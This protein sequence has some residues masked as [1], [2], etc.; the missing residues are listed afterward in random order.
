VTAPVSSA[1]L[2]CL[3]RALRTALGPADYGSPAAWGAELCAAAAALV[4]GGALGSVLVMDVGAVDHVLHT[5]L[6]GDAVR[7]YREEYVRHDPIQRRMLDRRLPVAYELDVAAPD[8]LR[9]DAFYNEFAVRYRLRCNFGVS[10]FQPG[11]L[12]HR[13]MLTFPHW[14]DEETRARAGAML[15][16]LAP[17]FAAGAESLGRLTAAPGELARVL[18]LLAEPTLVCDGRGAV[19]HQNT[20]LGALLGRVRAHGGP[21][22]EDAARAELRAL[23]AG[24]GALR[25]RRGAGGTGGAP[26][27]AVREFGAGAERFRA[28]ACFTAEHTLVRDALVWVTVRP[29]AAGGDP[30]G[31]APG[32]RGNG[33]GEDARLQ[34]RFGLTVQELAVA[35][36][37]AE[38]RTDPEIGAALGISP[39]TA[40]THAERVRRKL[41]VTRRTDVAAAL[42]AG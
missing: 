41:G 31:V 18:D 8:E 20:A 12:P 21:A 9:R 1:D 38:R 10:A 4:G 26:P 27:A 16:A 34:T 25:G 13:L 42:A 14:P 6:P 5:D 17:G 32:A 7:A 29:A 22:A 19:L 37:M 28:H 30:S 11:R 24:V 15:R 39:N 3:E 23:A 36:L 33:G 2:A 40:R 35:R